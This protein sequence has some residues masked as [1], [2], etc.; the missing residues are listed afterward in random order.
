MPGEGLAKIRHIGAWAI[1][2]VIT[3]HQ[4]YVRVSMT[5]TNKE[6]RA[7]AFG[8]HEIS[9]LMEERLTAN[10]ETLSAAT[11]YPQTVMVM[12]DRQFHNRGLLHIED[13]A[14]EFVLETVFVRV[15][16]VNNQ[17]LALHRENL[18]DQTESAMKQDVN[19]KEKWLTSFPQEEVDAKLVSL[20]LV[21]NV[22]TDQANTTFIWLT[23]KIIVLILKY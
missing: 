12:E 3:N 22:V 5:S 19:L 18:V 9:S 17:Q 1:G 21:S 7:S 14:C 11:Q 15:N 10:Y 16:F 23:S 2:K 8:R 13:C 4:K 6:T 20:F